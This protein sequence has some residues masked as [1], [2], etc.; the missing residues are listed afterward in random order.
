MRGKG[1]CYQR[2]SGDC[3]VTERHLGVSSV[4]SVVKFEVWVNE[5]LSKIMLFGAALLEQLTVQTV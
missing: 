5:P 1:H 2:W 3:N 4:D